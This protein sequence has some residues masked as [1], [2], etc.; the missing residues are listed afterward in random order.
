MHHPVIHPART[1]TPAPAQRRPRL[2]VDGPLQRLMD[3]GGLYPVF[4]PLLDLRKGTV[5]GHEAL[6]RGPADGPFHMPAELLQ[7]AARESMSREFELRCIDVTLHCWGQ[8]GQ[9]GLLFVN[10]S[11]DALVHAM[12]GTPSCLLERMLATSQ[13]APRTLVVELTERERSSDIRVLQ[14]AVKSLHAIGALL[15][16]DDFGDGHSSLRL[17]AELK[18]DFVKIDKFFTHAIASQS[19]NFEMVRAIRGISEAFGTRLVAEGIETADDLRVLRDL[20]IAY[21]QGYLLG[22]PQKAPVTQAP[23]VVMGVV[24]DKRIAVM[25]SVRQQARAGVLRGLPIIRAPNI[26]P[27]TTNDEVS[28][29]F[30]RRTDLHAVAIVDKGKPIALI[31][32]QGFMDHYARLYFREVHGRRPA[33]DYANRT[34]RVVELDDDVEE[35]IGILTSQDQRYLSDGFI[36]A[37]NDRYLG[38]GTGDQLVRAVTET[39]IEAARHANPL[40]FL[41]G[42]VPISMHIERLLASGADFVA[43]YVDLD[44]FKP[45]ND[46]Y[47]YWLGDEMLRAVAR[48]LSARCDERRDF[49]G[50]VG[51]DDFIVLFQS[52]DWEQRCRLII[53]DFAREAL[54]FYDEAARA[55][56]GIEAEDRHGTM[57][58]FPFVALSIGAVRVT[59]GLCRRVE[60]VANEAAIAKHEAKLAP[61]GLAVRA[62][63]PA[64]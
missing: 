56:G 52:R 7:L 10:M 20:D 1:D 60:E 5:F 17:W 12:A 2:S 51:G 53:E 30:Q 58:L 26:S 50:H 34:P 24:K 43:C 47:G 13:V 8:L 57:R 40:T 19:E 35:L 3:G 37:E 9:P 33:M 14:H 55:A 63:A 46:H 59:P 27:K 28:E 64:A 21:G 16:L 18:P 49:V 41:P 11:A 61:S 22:R 23:A 45:F 36:I 29:L 48:L 62:A 54:A 42:N 44:N 38:L 39:R 31:N 6:I 4:Q 32:R 15:A 25:P